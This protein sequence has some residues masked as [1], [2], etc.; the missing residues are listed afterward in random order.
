MAVQEGDSGGHG[1]ALQRCQ[2]RRLGPG[3]RTSQGVDPRSA[4]N[5][6]QVGVPKTRPLEGTRVW[7][8]FVGNKSL[9]P[10]KGGVE[11]R[12]RDTLQIQSGTCNLLDGESCELL[13]SLVMS[14]LTLFSVLLV[15]F[16]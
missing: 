15:L 16:I 5:G 6:N 7:W 14:L 8:S 4:R 13:A 1:L 11:A 2:A 12:C 9:V 10:T 3:P